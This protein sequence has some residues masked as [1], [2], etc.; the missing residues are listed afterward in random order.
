MKIIV[1]MGQGKTGTTSL[2]ESLHAAGA[3]LRSRK[4]L[5]PR[6]GHQYVAH[7]LLVALCGDPNRLPPWN[8]ERQGGPDGAV[9]AA[10]LAWNMTCEDIRRNRPELLVL[11]SEYLALT[12]DG[13]KARLAMLLSE[14]SN[15]ITP[16]IYVRHPIDHYRARLQQSIKH[17]DRH[18]PPV[19]QNLRQVVVD[20]EAV[21]G[22]GPE[23]VAF[24]RKELHGNDIVCDFATRFLAPW[25]Q[26]GDLPRLNANAG[27][28]AE[29]LVLLV[30]LRA[31]AGGTYEAS[32][33]VARLI[34]QLEALDRSD[35]P[36]QPLTLLPEVA[37]A[38]LRSATG[39][40]WLAETG[41]LRIPGL[42]VDKIDG[43]PPP[44]WM[45]TAPAESLFLHDPERLDRLRTLIEL[46]RPRAKSV[47]RQN[48]PSRRAPLRFRDRLLRFML[49]KLDSLQDPNKRA[50][51]PREIP[52]GA[53][54]E[55]G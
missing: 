43:A 53:A 19:H 32:R 20:T 11:S 25:V 21:F 27:L 7:H 26:A 12:T 2:Q 55:R 44:K 30:R 28:S 5:Y 24:D 4:V 47:K 31:E 10:Q 16:V 49:R 29:V 45:L 34:P 36:T 9:E 40:R 37:E 51:P 22:R 39:H 48:K 50:A 38:A 35:P 6:F 52:A 1:H 3:T 54:E 8:L 14:L 42:E 13:V 15:D 23:L 33:Q 17:K 46:R 41:R 18:F